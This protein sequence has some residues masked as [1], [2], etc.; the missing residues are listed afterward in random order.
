[1]APTNVL[2]LNAHAAKLIQE[3]SFQKASLVLRVALDALAGSIPHQSK[4][5][6]P[7]KISVPANRVTKP[8]L[9]IRSVPSF[10]HVFPCQDRQAF[11]MF[12]HALYMEETD[13][14][15][16]SSGLRQN[17][18]A[19]IIL[20]NLGLVYQL[21]GIRNLYE[22][23]V[24][25]ENA[26]KAYRKAVAIL[27]KSSDSGIEM[28]SLVYLSVLNNM[29]HIYSHF[30]EERAVQWCLDWLQFILVVGPAS[31]GD[32]SED[33]LTFRMNVVTLRGQKTAAASA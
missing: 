23:K 19:V 17:T 29:G 21:Q 20:Y 2:T 27:E 28:E 25:F 16:M 5:K 14:N 1:M 13:P 24:C 32:F 18:T 22:Q 3:G 31:E 12:D 8:L 30:S 10:K 7:G 11:V 15:A 9:P 33:Y 6:P 26:M 4:S